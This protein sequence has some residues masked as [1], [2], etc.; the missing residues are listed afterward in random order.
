VRLHKV[1]AV[2]AG[3]EH[4]GRDRS[5]RPWFLFDGDDLAAWDVAASA[6]FEH[7]TAFLALDADRYTA[8]EISALGKRLR[9]AGLVNLVAWGPGCGD[10]HYLFDLIYIEEEQSGS[11]GPFLLTDDWEDEPLA[12]GLWYALGSVG[13]DVKDLRRSPVVIGTDR[14]DWRRE[15]RS[16]LSD[17]EELIR[18]VVE[19]LP[20]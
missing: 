9:A 1:A 11:Q 17:E 6:G 19:D 14:D 20:D 3:L 12:Y 18:H 7:F 5:G 10:V 16:W 13:E 4:V 15:I 8:E 2:T